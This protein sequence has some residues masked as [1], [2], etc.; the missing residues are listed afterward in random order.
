M[1]MQSKKFFHEILLE[2]GDVIEVSLIKKKIDIQVYKRNIK[3]ESSLVFD[4][5]FTTEEAKVLMD[6]LKELIND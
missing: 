6:V 1:I 2:N 4:T 5:N 3:G